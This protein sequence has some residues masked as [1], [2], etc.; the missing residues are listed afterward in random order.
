MPTNAVTAASRCPFSTDA[1]AMKNRASV[2][3]VPGCILPTPVGLLSRLRGYGC[4]A[5]VNAGAGRG[6]PPL[7]VRPRLLA[8][9]SRTQYKSRFEHDH[10]YVFREASYGAEVDPRELAGQADQAGSR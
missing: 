7:R 5:E 3:P 4:H 2:S 1:I 9:G 8:Q 10:F 6:G